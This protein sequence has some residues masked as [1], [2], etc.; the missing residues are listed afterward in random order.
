[1]VPYLFLVLLQET[2]LGIASLLDYYTSNALV[3]NIYR[4]VSA[5]V[6]AFIYYSIP[7]MGPFRKLILW[8]TIG[9]CVLTFID[10]CFIESIFT[11][12]SYL[13]L[14]RGLVITFF[15]VL[16]LFSYFHLDNY[17]E[18]KYWHPL[19]WVTIGVAA[20]Y[21]VISLSLSFQK[22]MSVYSATLYGLKL[23]QVIPQVMSIFM[24][25]CFSYAFYLCQKK[26]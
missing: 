25:S 4:P 19:I 24:Y 23:Y 11:T 10:Y 15:A 14:A 22:Y 12:S 26:N 18:E 6:F 2:I 8:T 20:F 3:Y 17:A 1:M 9:Y 5:M 13:T 7:M 21:P 16:F